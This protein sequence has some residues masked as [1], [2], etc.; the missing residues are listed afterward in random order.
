MG[1]WRRWIAPRPLEEISR[2]RMTLS[3]AL[4]ARL[5]ASVALLHVAKGGNTDIFR[6]SVGGGAR[7]QLTICLS[8]SRRPP[9]FSPDGSQMAFESDRHR[10]AADLCHSPP[11]AASRSASA[12]GTGRYGTPV[13][14]PR[15]DYIAFTKQE[16]GRFH[17]GVDAHQRQRGAAVDRL[18]PRVEGPTWAPNGRVLMFNPRDGE[19]A[20]GAAGG[21]LGSTS[22]GATCSA[23]RRPV[24]PR[25]RRGPRG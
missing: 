16:G 10:R 21:L 15:G 2:V 14:S 4:H 17:I 20:D 23:W 3:A 12:R 9:R 24:W 22:R 13:W 8:R 7:T 18:L 25:I 5:A 1:T 6:V 19:G 11:A